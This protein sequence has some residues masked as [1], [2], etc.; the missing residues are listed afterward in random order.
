MTGLQGRS[1]LSRTNVS[2]P[3]V[4][5]HDLDRLL[6]KLFC[7]LSVARPQQARCSR[8]VRIGVLRRDNSGIEALERLSHC[9]EHSAITR[10]KH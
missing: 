10:I 2:R 9:G 1:A 8:V 7:H 5:K 4:L 3:R 6:A